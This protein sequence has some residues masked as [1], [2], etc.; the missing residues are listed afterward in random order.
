MKKPEK[1]PESVTHV[2]KMKPVGVSGVIGE[3]VLKTVEVALRQDSE[4]VSEWQEIPNA[5]VRIQRT[6]LKY[7]FISSIYFLNFF[8]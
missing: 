8:R 3:L 5:K 6:K 7:Y 2:Q 1:W 4:S